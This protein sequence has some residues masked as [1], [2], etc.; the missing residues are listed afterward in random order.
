MLLA[1]PGEG[2][3]E[4]ADSTFSWDELRQGCTQGLGE[5][6]QEHDGHV[7]DLGLEVHDFLQDTAED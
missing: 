6:G 4:A 7:D 1:V 3:E 5:N 2:V